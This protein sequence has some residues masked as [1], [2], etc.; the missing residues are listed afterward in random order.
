[1]NALRHLRIDERGSMLPIM[2][3]VL[4]LSLSGAALAVDLTRASALRA[5]LQTTADAA[6]LAA[7]TRLPN[8]DTAVAAA[9]RYADKNMPSERYGEVLARQDVEL[10]HW[11]AKT[12]SFQTN[13]SVPSAVRVTLRLAS[14]NDNA[15]AP[16]FAGVFGV[17]VMD[18]SAFATAARQSAACVIALEPSSNHTM[19]LDKNAQADALNCTVQVNSEKPNALRVLKSSSL[20]AMSICVAGGTQIHPHASTSPEPTTGCP[21]IVDPLAGLPAPSYGSC[22]VTD[23]EYVDA[24]ATLSPGVYCGGLEIAGDSDIT[25]DPGLYVIKDGRSRSV[26]V[27]P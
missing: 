14:S 12:R 24:N 18:L 1:M 9:L 20:E 21:P 13:G 2:A 3:A 23:G 6:A 5:E 11:D 4:L 26:T 22:D 25:L 17:E 27:R 8:A 10:G 19:T 7:A 15:I 16:F